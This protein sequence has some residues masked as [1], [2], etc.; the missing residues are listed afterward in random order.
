M[1][2]SMTGF[3]RS[4]FLSETLNV[5]VE[6]KTLNSKH[7]DFLIKTPKVFSE[8][9]IEIR[10][11]LEKQLERG[12][13]ILSID[14]QNKDLINPPQAINEPLLKAYYRKLQ[15]ISVDLAD[16][17][18]DLFR[19]AMYLPEV[20]SP[21]VSNGIDPEKWAVVL[22]KI[23]EAIRFCDDFRVQ[24]GQ[25]LLVELKNYIVEIGIH[26]KKIDELDPERINQVRARIHK[27]LMDLITD[28]EY[29]PNRFEQEL[30]YYLEK[31]DISEEKVRLKSHL[32]Y[33]LSE[34]ETSES[35]GKKL[36]FIAQEIGRE[37]NTIGSKA[38]HVDITRHVVLMKDNLEKIKEQLL[39]IL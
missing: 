22:E 34:L 26:L 20:I 19:L 16:D 29:D 8:K 7:L 31:L 36:N 9:E 23:R 37:I 15:Q 27:N 11:I 5:I 2:K 13:I 17:K 14:F 4:E 1:I 33:F 28:Q 39:N 6:I 21:E 38:N 35:N 18:A 30:I 10:N 24:E 32:D 25:T 3:G 12:K